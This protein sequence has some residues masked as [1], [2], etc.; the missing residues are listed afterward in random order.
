[1]D[2]DSIYEWLDYDHWAQVC[3]RTQRGSGWRF[4]QSSNDGD[5]VK[6]WYMDLAQDALFTSTL[7]KKI[8]NDTGV[9][10]VLD[11]VYANGQTHGL[12]GSVHQDVIDAEPGQCYT[13]LYYANNEWRPEWGGHTLFTTQDGVLSRYPTPNS[14]VWFDS[15]IPHVGLEPTRHCPEL[16]VTVAFKFHRP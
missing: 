10:W 3:N 2:I 1:M 8:R 15:T 14:M 6:F 11:R 16:R 5:G 9:D 12:C 4:Q 13:L 7:L